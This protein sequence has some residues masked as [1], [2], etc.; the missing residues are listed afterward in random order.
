MQPTDL[1]EISRAASDQPVYSSISV[2]VKNPAQVQLVEDAIKKMGF[3]T[4]SILD[5]S[6]SLRKF[7]SGADAFL[8]IFGSLALDRC[9]DRNREHAGDGNPRTP[10]RDRHHEGHWRE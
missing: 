10:P 5:A 8:G 1:R 3:G 7:F 9:V 2:R 4:F 6:R